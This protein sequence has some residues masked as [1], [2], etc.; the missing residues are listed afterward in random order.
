[1]AIG[2]EIRCPC[3]QEANR[4]CAGLLKSMPM[5]LEGPGSLEAPEIR[6]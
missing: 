4:A 3:A 5:L 1:M 2:L 6:H